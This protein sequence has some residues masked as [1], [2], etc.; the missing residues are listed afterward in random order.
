MDLNSDLKTNKRQFGHLLGT[1]F[2]A[3]SLFSTYMAHS[4]EV[5][6]PSTLLSAHAQGK[7]GAAA[8][9]SQYQDALLQN[10]ASAVFTNRYAVSASYLGWGN[11]LS[12]SIVDTQ[13][14]PVGGGVYYVRRDLKQTLLT[15][16]ALGNYA[17]SEEQMGF[18]L[19]GKLAEKLG[20]GTNIRYAYRKSTDALVGNASGWNFDVGAK[21]MVSS[22]ISLGVVAQNLMEDEVGV[23]PRRLTAGLEL[24]PWSGMSVSGQIFQVKGDNLLAGYTLPNATKENGYSVGAEYLTA[25]SVATRV[26]Y[27]SN[28]NWNQKLLSFGVGYTTNEY[29]VDY[30][31]QKGMNKSTE[32]VHT[33]SLTGF[34]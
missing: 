19:M 31:F 14:G 2:L 21:Y 4:F 29:T 25:I 23:Y 20:I 15:S 28:P 7:G 10:P 11:S 27:T 32:E 5:A 8:A 17:R 12:A 24:Q 1:V 22:Q 18:S 30:A 6:D 26:G 13:S 9:S 34:F 33:V 3:S 16:S